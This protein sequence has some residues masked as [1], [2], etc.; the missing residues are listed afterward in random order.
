MLMDKYFN[1]IEG[2]ANTWSYIP[3]ESFE[4]VLLT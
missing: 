4:P 1:Y 3:F 2:I